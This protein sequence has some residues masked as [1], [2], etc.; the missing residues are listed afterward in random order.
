MKTVKTN[1]HYSKEERETHLWYNPETKMWTMESNISKHFNKAV[2]CG[3]TVETKLVNEDDTPVSM[4]L[5]AAERAITIKTP[6][7]RM[8]SDK[9]RASCFGRENTHLIDDFDD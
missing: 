2:K 5:T 3:W 8:V 6:V 1:I 4:I 9:Q 7:K